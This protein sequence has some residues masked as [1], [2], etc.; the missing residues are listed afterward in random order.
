VGVYGEVAC[1]ENAKV[2]D[3]GVVV[4]GDVGA[5]P[6]GGSKGRKDGRG[7]CYETVVKCGQCCG[8]GRG[9]TYGVAELEERIPLTSCRR[10]QRF[11]TVHVLTSRSVPGSI[12]GWVC[13]NAIL[14]ILWCYA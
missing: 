3:D 4:E 13:A 10:A 8:V 1:G 6:W 9:R 5:C 11:P 2:G 14:C 12:P 7:D